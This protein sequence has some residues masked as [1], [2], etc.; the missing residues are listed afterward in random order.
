MD[1][2][3]ACRELHALG[4]SNVVVTL[5]SE[6]VYLSNNGNQAEW[7]G[8]EVNAVDTTG[9]GD[10]FCGALAACLAMAG[11]FE[12]AITYSQAAAAVACTQL[13]AQSSIPDQLTVQAFLD[14]RG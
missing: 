5:G 4:V 7:P 14:D 11:S 6:G 13:G 2:E 1:N 8:F 3:E 10:T 12:E 9:A